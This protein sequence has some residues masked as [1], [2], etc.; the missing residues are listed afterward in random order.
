MIRAKKEV[1][2]SHLQVE[3]LNK[4]VF[5]DALT[6]V[7]N[8]GG[9]NEYIN[10]LQERIDNREQVEFAVIIFDSNDLKLIN[11]QHGHDKGDLYLQTASQLICRV[12]KHSPVFRIGGDEFAVILMNEDYLNREM[13]KEQ[14]IQSAKEISASTDNEWE[15]V[16]MSMGMAEYDPKNDD[17][18]DDV[19]Q[20]ADKNMYEYK[21]NLK[22]HV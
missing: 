7:R 8:K 13:L 9:F 21:R 20:H 16:S 10:S 11:D 1:K 15:R 17:S 3:N 19:V 4:R 12:Y 5:V 18:I 22:G 6:S 2:E 14:F